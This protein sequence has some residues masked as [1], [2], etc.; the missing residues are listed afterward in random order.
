MR[1]SG[2]L[3]TRCDSQEGGCGFVAYAV[4]RATVWN[5]ASFD[6]SGTQYMSVETALQHELEREVSTAAGVAVPLLWR[7]G[8]QPTG[9]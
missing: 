8:R 2:K 1:P 3:R 9:Y 4:D 7:P 6:Q 5:L